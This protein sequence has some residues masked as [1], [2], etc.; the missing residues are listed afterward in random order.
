MSI[1]EQYF[2]VERLWELYSYN[3]LTGELYSHYTKKYLSKKERKKGTEYGRVNFRINGACHSASMQE[4]IWAWCTGAYSPEGLT[5]DHEDRIRTN[6]RIQ[7]LRLAT[8][9]QQ[10]QNRAC[11]NGG[12]TQDHRSNVWYARIYDVKAQKHLGTFSNK[13][14][15]QQAY[16]D[17]LI[18]LKAP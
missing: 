11:F 7:N 4:V 17:A 8:P 5:V 1:V 16:K 3:P 18:G 12:V 9:R 6:N 14:E 2:P 10:S 15:A 13:A